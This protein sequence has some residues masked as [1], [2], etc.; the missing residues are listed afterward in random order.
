MNEASP[1]Y[2]GIYAGHGS[3]EDVRESFERS[4]LVLYFG[5]QDTDVTTYFGTAKL[6]ES[7]LITF[8]DACI[9]IKGEHT[10]RL[11]LKGAVSA[12][13]DRLSSIY[14]NKIREGSILRNSSREHGSISIDH[15]GPITHDWLWPYIGNFFRPGDVVVSETGTASFGILE[16]KFPP[17]C[18][19]VNASLWASIG[20][21]VG[22]TQGLALAANEEGTGRRTILFEG[23]GSFQVSCQEVSTMI[24]EDLTVTM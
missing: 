8:R 18:L 4:D 23:D 16:T 15:D 14:P 6:S 10:F 13:F 3:D 1:C 19:L 24:K 5:P 22:A 11:S 9:E 7:S 17:E 21:C 12:L 20:Y 2:G